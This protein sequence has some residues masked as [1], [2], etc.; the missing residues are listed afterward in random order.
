VRPNYDSPRPEPKRTVKPRKPTTIGKPVIAIHGTE[1]MLESGEILPYDRLPEIICS[2]ASSIVVAHQVGHI[3]RELDEI[4]GS[5]PNWQFRATPVERQVWAPNRKYRTTIRDTTINFFGFKG[6]SKKKGHYHYPVS[7]QTFCLKTANEIRRG[8]PEGTATILKL[9]EWGKDLRCFLQE[10]KLNLSPT[11]GGIAAQ[12]LRDSRF[13]P[14]ARRK[15]PLQTNRIAREKLPGNYYKLY[16]AKEGSFHY[17]AAYLDQTSAHH[18]AAKRLSFPDANTLR[19]RGYHSTLTDRPYARSGTP[20]FERLIKHHGLFYLAFEAPRF[21]PTSFPLPECDGPEGYRRGFFYSNEIPYLKELG[22]RVRHIIAC[23]TSPSSETGLNRYA[24]WAADEIA[25]SD[26]ARKPWLKPTLLA[27]YGILAAKPKKLEFGYKQAEDAVEAKYPCGSGFLT[28]QAKRMD[29][30]HEMAMANVIHRGMIEAETRLE[31]L[32][33][34]K[35]LTTRGYEILA[36]YADSVFV[37]DGQEL[38]LLPPPWRLQAHLTAL[39]FLNSTQFTSR[40]IDKLPGIPENAR[41][42]ARLPK[43]PKRLDKAA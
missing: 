11:S 40:E 23:W 26:D 9:M 29:R 8:V 43:R 12:L 30:L 24:D 19:R 3:V 13:Y 14:N 16:G 7:P 6:K 25:G 1:V 41:L 21:L 28:V 39:R 37:K 33:L 22:V 18:S 2:Q 42:R 38:P 36:V 4:F 31:S 20:K 35:D 17:R 10:Q 15:V 32:R 5:N 27:T 34:A